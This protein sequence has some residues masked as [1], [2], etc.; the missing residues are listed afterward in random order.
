MGPS[1]ARLMPRLTAYFA[2][3]THYSAF[4][5]LKLVF[6]EGWFQSRLI[7]LSAS[8]HYGKL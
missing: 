8:G 2:L 3:A 6:L 1:K 4:A 7:L 5:L